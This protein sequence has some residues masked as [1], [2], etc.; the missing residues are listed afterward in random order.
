MKHP[1]LSKEGGGAAVGQG[2]GLTPAGSKRG[3][4]VDTLTLPFFFLPHLSFPSVSYC[5]FFLC[6]SLSLPT[7]S[8]PHLLVS[9]A[10]SVSLSFLTLSH[11]L[12]FCLNLCPFSLCSVLSHSLCPCVCVFTLSP[13]LIP[14]SVCVCVSP[15]ILICRCSPAEQLMESPGAHRVL[16]WLTP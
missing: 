16:D 13:A 15:S 9:L 2:Q 4:R 10:L 5:F 3:G 12:H 8:F 6:F 1:S 14:L 11:P 7:L